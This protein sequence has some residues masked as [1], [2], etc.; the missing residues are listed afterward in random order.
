VKR[1]DHLLFA[2]FMPEDAYFVDIMRHGD[3]TRDHVLEVMIREWPD[4]G[5][6]HELPGVL[7][8]AAHAS[9]ADR[10]KLRSSAINAPFEFDRKVYVPARGLTSAGTSLP[11]TIAVNQVF[12]TIQ[13]FC[14]ELKEDPEYVSKAI[15]RRGLTPPAKPD[16]HF[17]FF[18]DGSYGVLEAQTGFRFILKR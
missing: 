14:R 15:A 2:V 9:E 3:W 17:V 4:A 16:L 7:G 6:V 5:L 12:H 13:W 8:L 10:K 1:T 18:D 11:I